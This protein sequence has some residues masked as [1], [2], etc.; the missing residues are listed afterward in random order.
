MNIRGE[1]RQCNE[2]KVDF[3]MDEDE[4]PGYIILDVYVS[5]YLDTSLIDVDSHPTYVTIIIKNKTL[6]LSFPEEVKC[7]LGK[8]ERS[9]VTGAL[10]LTFPKVDFQKSAQR[11]L[12][13]KK[14]DG[15][16]EKIM[17]T[18]QPVHNTLGEQVSNRLKKQCSICDY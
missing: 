12:Y 3:K 18:K 11:S 6:R 15:K 14:D 1:I 10:R 9:Q 8:A 13:G 17:K 5:K 16:R 2:M 4:Q 7:D